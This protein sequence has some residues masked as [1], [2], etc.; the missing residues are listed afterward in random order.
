MYES[1]QVFSSSARQSHYVVSDFFFNY[2]TI[3]QSIFFF[4]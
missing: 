2:R 4:F 3:V 1:L